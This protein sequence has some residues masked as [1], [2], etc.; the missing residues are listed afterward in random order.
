VL[1]RRVP[2][3]LVTGFL[4]TVAVSGLSACR[5]SPTVAAYVGDE[6]VTIAELESAIAERRSD[7]EIDAF[8]TTDPGAFARRVLSL[9]VDE[10]VHAAAAQRYDIDVGNDD[11][12][13]RID[14]LL[15]EDDPEAV[16]GQLAAQ[17]IGEAD[18]FENV[19]QQLIRQELAAEGGADAPGEEALRARYGEVRNSLGEYSFGY[20]A[21]PDAAAAQAVLGQLTADP[22]SYAAVAAQY[23]DALTM[24]ALESRAEADLAQLPA[25]LVEGITTAAPNTG[26]TVPGPDPGQ[27]V[28]VFVAGTVYPPFEEVRPQLEQEAEET[29]DAAGTEVV[30]D[31][32]S[33]LRVRLNPRFDEPG[34]NSVVDILEDDGT[35]GSAGERGAPPA[36]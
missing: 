18:V 23:P 1:K 5:T 6:R 29:A 30:E 8:A 25:R 35:S 11:V 16:F 3:V 22:A 36:E 28:V 26:F 2:R 13:A 9:L 31:V 34:E 20:I 32:R 24:T 27:V 7:P 21:T 15:G 12:R 4:L 10:Q 17:G 19:R 14:Q 33:D